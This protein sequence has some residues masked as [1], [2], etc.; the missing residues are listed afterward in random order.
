MFFFWW[1]WWV[2]VVVL[3]SRFIKRKQQQRRNINQAHKQTTL[4]CRYIDQSFPMLTPIRLRCSRDL[5]GL[6]LAGGKFSL[7]D[8]SKGIDQAANVAIPLAQA[9]NLAGAD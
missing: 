5:S 7:K 3:S 2:V 8:L 1:W 6:D 9:S 4:R